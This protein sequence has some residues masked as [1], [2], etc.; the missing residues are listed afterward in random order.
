MTS[1]RKKFGPPPKSL[2][3]G[4]LKA[5]SHAEQAAVKQLDAKLTKRDKS[6]RVKKGSHPRAALA[7]M[8]NESHNAYIRRV[9]REAGPDMID[10]LVNIAKDSRRSDGARV[11]AAGMVLDRAYGRATQVVET[12]QARGALNEIP[13]ETLVELIR[14]AQEKQAVKEALEIAQGEREIPKLESS[15]PDPDI[16]ASD[17]HE[18]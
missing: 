14:K 2:P 18:A 15:L 17:G 13:T 4:D 12:I 16:I 6:G 8:N 9:A 3:F 5:L 7:R 11:K 10:V 1:S